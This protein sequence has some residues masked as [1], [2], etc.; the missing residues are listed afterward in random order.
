MTEE[1]YLELREAGVDQFSVSLDFPDDRH[2]VFRG[3]PGLYDHISDLIPRC[4]R[5]GYDNIVLNSCITSENVDEINR[6]G[7]QGARVGREHVLQRLLGA[8]HRLPRLLPEHARATGHPQPGA[9][10]GGGAA[11]LDQLARELADHARGHPPLLRE[12][13]RARLQG[14]PAFSGGD[15]RTACS[16][17]ARCSSS[18]TRSKSA[19]A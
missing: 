7:R 2:D 3:L 5:H 16:S 15:R 10:P 14:R 8:A 12:Q 19:P 9:R 18:G 1:R 6:H 17:P 13:R 4:A 11:R